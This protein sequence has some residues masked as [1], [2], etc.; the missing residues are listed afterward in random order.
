MHKSSGRRRRPHLLPVSGVAAAALFM[1]DATARRG[2]K[3]RTASLP[4]A[5]SPWAFRLDPGA[6]AAA[7]EQLDRRQRPVGRAYK[8]ITLHPMA[9]KQ[10]NFAER[11]ARLKETAYMLKQCAETV[12]T[13]VQHMEAAQQRFSQRRSS[14][15]QKAGR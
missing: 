8:P 15:T 14:R 3:A 1:I 5:A 9:D 12:L 10:P 4:Y 2:V 13:E 11:T 6:G 7:L